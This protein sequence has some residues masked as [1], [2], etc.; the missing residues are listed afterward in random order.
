MII[1]DV[2]EPDKIKF[3]CD[4]VESIS[5][6]YI[7][8]GSHEKWAFER[9]THFDLIGSVRDGRVWNQLERLK[10]LEKQGYKVALILEGYKYLLFK[11]KN[12][13]I[14]QSQYQGILIAIAKYGIPIITTENMDLTIMTLKQIDMS[15]GKVSEFVRPTI[16]KG[17]RT[18]E[19]EA[20]DML[21]AIDGVGRKTADKLLSAYGSIKELVNAE[22]IDLASTVSIREAKHI[23]EVLNTRFR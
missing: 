14:S 18:I 16:S 1:G 21:C 11:N 17:G 22:T 2:Y 13:K 9:K 7:I 15:A 6:D 12:I 23:E 19:E 3:A 4:K 10:D 20:S 8:Q 5:V